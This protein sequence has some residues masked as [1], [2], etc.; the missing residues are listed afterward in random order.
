MD[1]V[2]K[3]PCPEGVVLFP[4]DGV[5]RSADLLKRRPLGADVAAEVVELIDPVKVQRGGAVALDAGECVAVF[6][7]DGDDD[8]GGDGK[9]IHLRKSV[10]CQHPFD[11]FFHPVDFRAALQQSPADLG[12][13]FQQ[14]VVVH[15]VII[16]LYICLI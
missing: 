8:A 16:P 1:A 14:L 13:D 11:R 9:N 6:V 12:G 3:K 15:P 2:K 5:Q 7:I 10:S 4:H